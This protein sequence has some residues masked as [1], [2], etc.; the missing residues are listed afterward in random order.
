MRSKAI[1]ASRA[2]TFPSGLPA[3]HIQGFQTGIRY[4]ASVGVVSGLR[5]WLKTS[6]WSPL[7]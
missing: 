6:A 7:G 4:Y 2:E 5:H 3:E 1:L